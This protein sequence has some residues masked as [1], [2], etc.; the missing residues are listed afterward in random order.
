[1]FQCDAGVSHPAPP[2]SL[3][4]QSL[5]SLH[6]DVSLGM[7]P[8]ASV[9]SVSNGEVAWLFPL[10]ATVL[11]SHLVNV[12]KRILCVLNTTLTFSSGYRFP[13]ANSY[14]KNVVQ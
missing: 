14:I 3:E 4:S 2:S 12:L 11:F 10:Y 1:M 7:C 5:L 9:R 13:Q 6:G 8:R